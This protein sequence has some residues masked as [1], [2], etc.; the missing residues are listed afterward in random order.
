MKCIVI[1]DIS[2]I[3]LN[4]NNFG[5]YGKVAVM[6]KRLFE[7][8]GMSVVIAGGPV[9]KKKVSDDERID[10]P[11]DLELECGASKFR[12]LFMKMKSVINGIVLFSK[13]KDS[14]VIC[15]PYSFPAW[16]ISVLFARQSTEIYLIEYKDECHSRFNDILFKLAKKRIKGI[17]CPNDMVGKAYGL[18]YITVP[19]Y[20]I[21][22]LKARK[23]QTGYKYDFGM[24]GIMSLGKDIDDVIK[25]FANTTYKVIIAGY[26][27]DLQRYKEFVK[28]STPNITIINK[29][30]TDE[31]YNS[32]L[33]ST[34]YMLLP[35][36]KKYSSASSGVI[37]DIL[38]SGRPL[39]TRDF[40]NFHFVKEY[41]IGVL[42]RD[43]IAELDYDELLNDENVEAMCARID[44]FLEDNFQSGMK[45]RKYVLGETK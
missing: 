42:Y 8:S 9:Y 13:V 23:E 26:F 32:I 31:E 33:T 28:K 27:H 37:Y 5:H 19:D 30:L 18:P 15:Q 10:L 20:I 38:F 14:A 45:L 22:E 17:I 25:S 34:K 7:N 2:S 16:M 12:A 40:V 6:Y 39:V 35:Y 3:K 36:N 44:A 1:A 41:G 24:V 11:Y 4:G 29:Y 21:P 43:T